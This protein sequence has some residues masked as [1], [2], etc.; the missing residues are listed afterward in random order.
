MSVSKLFDLLVE[1]MYLKYSFF[2]GGGGVI[3]FLNAEK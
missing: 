3:F 2:F 1:Y